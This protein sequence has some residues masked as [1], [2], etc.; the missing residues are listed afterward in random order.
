MTTNRTRTS[1]LGATVVALVASVFVIA[2]VNAAERAT[3]IVV[4]GSQA[5]TSAAAKRA[6]GLGGQVTFSYSSVIS[7][8]SVELPAAAA[9]ALAKSQ[10]VRWMEAD[11]PVSVF[12]TQAGATWGLDRI[13]QRT[14]SLDGV[15]S[16]GETG[17]NV[18]AYVVDTGVM[19]GHNEFGGRVADGFTSINDGLGTEDAHGHGTHVAGT[20]AGATYGVAKAATVVPVRVLDATGRG[21]WSGIIAGLDWIAAT[22]V[23]GTQ[24]VAN[25]SLGGGGNLAVDE[26]VRNLI[27]T[28]VTV[29]VAAGNSNADASLY[30]PARVTEAITVGAS[31]SADERASYSNYGTVVDL[32][33]PGSSVTSAWIGSATDTA[34]ASGT[35]M[36]APHVAGAVVLALALNPGMSPAQV[37]EALTANATTNV[38]TNLAGSANLLLH[39]GNYLEPVQEP[40]S[41]STGKAP[42]KEEGT[43]PSGGKK[44]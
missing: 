19:A 24:A 25:M 13:D 26:A 12:D 10:G 16:Y 22:H 21:S 7:G 42:V 15:Y 1:V 44:R 11:G 2:P 41:P 14:Q 9:A 32:F 3:Y 38:L 40:T 43:K 17:A 5:Q 4:T 30:S 39:T 8:F 28:G 35:S 27:S 34:T 20:I 29:V 23:D 18:V 6:E 31:T 37:A 33:A 36:A